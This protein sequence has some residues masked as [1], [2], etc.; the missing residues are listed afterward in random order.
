MRR[1][2]DGQRPI[3]HGLRRRGTTRN[4]SNRLQVTRHFVQRVHEQKRQ[5]VN[6]IDGTLTNCLPRRDSAHAISVGGGGSIGP[7]GMGYVGMAGPDPSKRV[8]SHRPAIAPLK[9]PGLA[10]TEQ[11]FRPPRC[12]LVRVDVFSDR[13]PSSAER[14]SV[15]R[16]DGRT[17][18]GLSPTFINSNR[19]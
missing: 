9:V 12:P 6:E 10:P 5:P 11:H 8:T 15:A 1:D 18:G 3:I 14:I 16:S 4:R 13:G 19:R 17:L 7:A 2:I